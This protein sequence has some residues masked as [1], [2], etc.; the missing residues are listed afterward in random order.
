MN[1]IQLRTSRNPWT[2]AVT[3]TPLPLLQTIVGSNK[4]SQVW[5]KWP[6]QS[7]GPRQLARPP[8]YQMATGTK[9]TGSSTAVGGGGLEMERSTQPKRDGG[10]EV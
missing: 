8:S 4:G 1:I 10:K 2:P 3:V 7:E 9:A 6:F 5:E